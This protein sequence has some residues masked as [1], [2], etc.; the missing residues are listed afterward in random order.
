VIK[1]EAKGM[2]EEGEGGEKP[3]RGKGKRG[4]GKANV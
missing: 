2:A 1:M 3:K 4:S